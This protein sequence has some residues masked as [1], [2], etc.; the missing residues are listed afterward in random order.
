MAQKTIV[1]L[2]DDLDGSEADETISF[3]L[4]GT[5]YEIDLSTAHASTLRAGLA[6]FVA[7]AR[8]TGGRRA[9]RGASRG[10]R[11]PSEVREWAKEQGIE[12]SE[13]GRIPAEVMVKFQEAKGT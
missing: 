11:A 6:P 12:V 8:K 13:R 1:R 9:A 4:D 5:Q 7:S 3:M 10:R 2:L